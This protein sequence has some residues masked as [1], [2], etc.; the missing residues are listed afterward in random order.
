MD[1]WDND[2]MLRSLLESLSTILSSNLAP[3]TPYEP[4]N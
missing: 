3:L 4:S 2:D 1:L